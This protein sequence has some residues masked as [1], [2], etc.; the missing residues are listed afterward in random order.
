MTPCACS[1]DVLTG[2]VKQKTVSS[3]GYKMLLLQPY[4]EQHVRTWPPPRL[5]AGEQKQ[6]ALASRF[7]LVLPQ[8]LL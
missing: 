2:C 5:P 8:G 6:V 4:T 1:K 3:Q 7:S